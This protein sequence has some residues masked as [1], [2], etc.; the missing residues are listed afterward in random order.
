MFWFGLLEVFSEVCT[1]LLYLKDWPR[2]S[3]YCW[4]TKLSLKPVHLP[5][6]SMVFFKC[7][8]FHVA[9][10]QIKIYP[11]TSVVSISV[12]TK[13]SFILF[14]V[15]HIFFFLIYPNIFTF[16][17]QNVLSGCRPFSRVFLRLNISEPKI[18][19][20]FVTVQ[21]ALNCL[22]C[23]PLCLHSLGGFYSPW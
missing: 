9:A 1:G 16:L 10:L 5:I 21:G 7:L 3:R 18:W 12:Y 15:F 14:V 2:A 17:Q 6:T 4:Q 11:W 20:T 23:K 13:P 19:C 8:L 22:L